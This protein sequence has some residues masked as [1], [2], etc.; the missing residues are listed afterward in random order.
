MGIAQ[1]YFDEYLFW[2]PYAES[3]KWESELID[4]FNIRGP[5]S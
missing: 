1:A 2:Y 5:E 3:L 4:D